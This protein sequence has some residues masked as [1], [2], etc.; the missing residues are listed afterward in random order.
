MIEVL[1]LKQPSQQVARIKALRKAAAFA[2]R[3]IRNIKTGTPGRYD[4]WTTDIT[5]S[6]RHAGRVLFDSVEIAQ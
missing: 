2:A 1:W 3:V 6:G 5:K 4:G